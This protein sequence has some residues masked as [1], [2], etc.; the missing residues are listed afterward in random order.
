MKHQR[1]RNI[2]G[3][4][5]AFVCAVTF[6][7]CVYRAPDEDWEKHGRIRLHLNWQTRGEYPSGMTY[8]FYK[9]GTGRP[10][11]RSGNASGYEGTLPSGQYKVAV[12][13]MDHTNLVLEMEDGYD[14]ALGKVRQVSTLKSS[15]VHLAHPANLYGAGCQLINVG[16]EEM[17]AEELYPTGLVKT[18][19]MNIRL[20]G[21]DRLSPE[22]VS[23]RLTGVSSHIHIP[24]GTPLFDTPAFMLFEPSA[25]NS[26]I[27]STSLSMFGLSEGGENGG[28]VELYL[29][30]KT[31]DG[32]EITS[33][34]DISKEISNA[35]NNGLS[36]HIILDLV[37]AFDEINGLT[38]TITDWK[39]GTGEAGN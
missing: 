35:F 28:P 20:S 10:L 34:T 21:V 8:Y 24:S 26:D 31:K 7:S 36:A 1:N 29:T 5:V 19:E 15:P 2:A 12:C 18:F 33:Y 14:R 6:P 30:L 27:Y 25:V 13:N 23:G 38:I 39:E 9:D 16:G 17:V 37:I 3:W 4:L 32:K 22:G 11:I